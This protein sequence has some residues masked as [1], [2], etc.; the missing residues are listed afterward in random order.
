VAVDQLRAFIA[1]PR[2]AADIDAI[3]MAG[4]GGFMLRVLFAGGLSA[5]EVALRRSRRAWVS[6]S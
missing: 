6:G 2:L 3:G 4:R 1:G 5:A